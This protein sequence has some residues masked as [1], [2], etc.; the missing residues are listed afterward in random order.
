MTRVFWPLDRLHEEYETRASRGNK[1]IGSLAAARLGMGFR[2]LAMLIMAAPLLAA[3]DFGGSESS[4]TSPAPLELP[5]PEGVSSTAD[6]FS[7]VLMWTAPSDSAEIVGYEITRDG[8]LL[9][10]VD[11]NETMFT[12][13]NLKPGS[14]NYTVRSVGPHGTS[15]PVAAQVVIRAPPLRAARLEGHYSV[16]TKVKSQSGYANFGNLPS[17]AWDFEPKCREDACDVL[18]R[19]LVDKRIHAK[20]NRRKATY[21][22]DYKGLFLA[23]CRGTRSVSSVH[24]R[25]K[26]VKAKAL[27]GLW[28]I[29]KFE[30]TLTS[31][32][33]PQFGCVSGH[34]VQ[35]IKG[36]LRLTD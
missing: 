28:R 1:E 19:D 26:A 34:A 10:S 3:C 11:A 2:L 35:T 20:L 32:E 29:T 4:A 6:G 33:A 30:G 21:T 5:T 23:R 25:I 18:W 7:V 17:F 15:K 31:S 36:M 16:K 13:Y 22:G 8:S 9:D 24:V 27:G 12:D 14:Y